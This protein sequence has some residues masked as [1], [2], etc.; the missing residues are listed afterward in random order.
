MTL[1]S[2][3]YER[4]LQRTGSTLHLCHSHIT[5]TASRIW[6]FPRMEE[7]LQHWQ[8]MSVCWS[9]PMDPA[10]HLDQGITWV[11]NKPSANLRA[12]GFLPWSTANPWIE[13]WWWR[14][15]EK[16]KEI[17][18]WGL[19]L[20]KEASSC[21]PEQCKWGEKRVCSSPWSDSTAHSD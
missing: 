2:C 14:Q 17:E 12:C 8:L 15:G 6:V 3:I 10:L 5:C 7:P 13:C 1:F 18:R 16:Q 4:P 9:T 20:L 21:H 19:V 11:R